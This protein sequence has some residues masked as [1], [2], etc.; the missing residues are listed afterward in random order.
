MLIRIFLLRAFFAATLL[1]ASDNG[2]PTKI[3]LDA[4]KRY[5]I[6]HHY[7]IIAK[8]HQ[9]D[10][11][12]ERFNQAEASFLPKVGV[13]GGAE[14]ESSG[15]TSDAAGVGYLF[16]TYN[17]FNGY[18][19]QGA[20]S[21]A[22]LEV[23][24]YRATLTAEEFLVALEVEEYFHLYLYKKDIVTLKEKYIQLNDTHQNY[25]KKSRASGA[26]S[27]TDVMEFELKAANLKSDLVALKQELDDARSNL[28][29]LLGDEIGGNIEPVG[30]LQHQHVKGNLMDYLNR[31]EA[32]SELVKVAAKNMEIA[33]LEKDMTRSRWLPQI[34]LEAKAGYLPLM[35]R[36]DRNKPGVSVAL[37]AKLDLFSGYEATY[38]KREKEAARLRSEAEVKDQINTVIRKVESS[39]RNIKVIESRADIEKDNARFTKRYYD[40]VLG[41]YKRGFKNSSDLSNAVDRLYEAELRKKSLEYEFIKER[42]EAE[43][44]LGSRIDVEIEKDEL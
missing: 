9:V 20:R 29:R 40:S 4:A 31:I 16:G 24:K 32:S 11:M 41:E 28:R 34:D 13:A 12:R 30:H 7:G 26:V 25:V 5:A 17:L 1:K 21:I 19:D 6:E 39:F 18:R 22:N 2:V 43:R 44:V 42:I 10:E 35:E 27:E 8:R 15:E 3:D 14:F 37:V 33:S 38:E 36:A 23:E